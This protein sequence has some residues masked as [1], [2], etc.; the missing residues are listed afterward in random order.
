MVIRPAAGAGLHTVGRDRLGCKTAPLHHVG[1][2]TALKKREGGGGKRPGCQCQVDRNRGIFEAP[3]DVGRRPE[4]CAAYATIGQ[5]TGTVLKTAAVG[6]GVSRTV[7]AMA[8]GTRASRGRSSGSPAG[9]RG[10]AT[11]DAALRAWRARRSHSSL[12]V[13]ARPS[14]RQ[15]PQHAPC[16]HPEAGPPSS[17]SSSNPAPALRRLLS[18]RCAAAAAAVPPLPLPLL[19]PADAPAPSTKLLARRCSRA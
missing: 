6:P 7:R 2:P 10:S 4:P 16:R 5:L 8:G 17:P 9:A 3:P 12:A 13:T 1:R 15:S 19:L 18:L 11:S 14:L